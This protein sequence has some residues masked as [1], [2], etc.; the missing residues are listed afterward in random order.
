[1]SG[2]V[3]GLAVNLRLA[4]LACCTL[5]LG[6][7]LMSA[8]PLIDA[9]SA[10]AVPFTGKFLDPECGPEP[11]VVAAIE[12]GQY[13]LKQGD[14]SFVVYFMEVGDGWYVNQMTDPVKE[15]KAVDFSGDGSLVATRKP[16]TL[17][18]Y[19]LVK[20]ADGN[21]ILH[22]SDCHEELDGISGLERK[23]KTCLI[24]DLEALKTTSNMLAEG[25]DSGK[26]HDEFE[27]L[28]PWPM[29]VRTN[30]NDTSEGAIAAQN[31]EQME[32]PEKE[33]EKG[34]ARNSACEAGYLG[35]GVK[36]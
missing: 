17:T 34:E 6:G 20:W 11:V 9:E 4:V 22:N 30:G 7:C 12:H 33:F 10:S 24:N 8:E 14:Q 25:I 18:S 13:S 23:N 3:T 36:N 19:R 5:L 28:R 1:M 2:A 21:L 15:E 27:V 26:I 31:L 29:E 16:T 32:L 35:Y